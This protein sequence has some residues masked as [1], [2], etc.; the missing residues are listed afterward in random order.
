MKPLKKDARCASLLHVQTEPRIDGRTVTVKNGPATAVV[1][2]LSPADAVIRA[3]GGPGR[4]FVSEGVNYPPE[5]PNFSEAG[6]GRI[7]VVSE[8]DE[9]ERVIEIEIVL[10]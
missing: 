6:W 8:S 1:R 3:V 2:V 10:R 9:P 5:R 7:E 4:E